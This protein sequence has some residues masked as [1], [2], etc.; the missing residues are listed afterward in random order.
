MPQ[1]ER[2]REL[3]ERVVN[4]EARNRPL[5]VEELR[6]AIRKYLGLQSDPNAV[7][8]VLRMPNTFTSREKKRAA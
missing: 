8:D 4:A 7:G 5:A 3:C 2:I 1:E 6:M